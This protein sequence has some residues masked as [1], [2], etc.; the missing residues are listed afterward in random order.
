MNTKMILDESRSR[1]L[2]MSKIHERLYKSE[3]LQFINIRDNI[4]D[5]VNGLVELY[6]GR[7][8]LVTFDIECDNIQLAIDKAIPCTLILNEVITNSLKYAFKDYNDSKITIRINADA[9]NI[10]MIIKDNGIGFPAGHDVNKSS[11]LGLL[12]VK[13]FARQISG[14]IELNNNNGAEFILTFPVN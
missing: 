9:E 14:D 3:N 10:R 12:I 6:N 13:T 5:I 7:S 2:S 4:S 1:I 8:R 11:S